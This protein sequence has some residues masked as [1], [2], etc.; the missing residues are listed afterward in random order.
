MSIDTRAWGTYRLG[1]LFDIT[2]G[3]YVP[4][5]KRTQGD[6]P[7]VT[8]TTLNNG[9]DGTC[10][11]KPNGA[12]GT[13]T[14][15]RNGS[16]GE[17][18]YQAD[19]Y[20]AT[21]DVHILT[22]K[23]ALS[24][25]SALFIC[26]VLRLEK[27]RYSYGRKWSLDAMKDTTIRLPRRENGTPDWKAMEAWVVAQPSYALMNAAA[28][29]PASKTP[30]TLPPINTWKPFRLDELFEVKRGGANG[31]G[32]APLV[33]AS[34]RN[35]GITGISTGVVYPA[36][37]ITVS[38]NGSI[39]EAFYQPAPFTA[40]GDVRVLEPKV[41]LTNESALFVC[42]VIRAERFRYSYG[43][44]WGLEQMRSTMLRLPTDANGDPDWNLMT[45]Y[46]RTLPYSGVL[47]S[48]QV[49]G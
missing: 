23:T 28:E 35:N 41:K 46:I 27:F 1:D 37:M 16:I 10:G 9:R 22:P 39:G 36:G 33:S 40:S 4:V 18:F 25:E 49:T 45:E 30:A 8:S 34:A 32:E 2:R 21:D 14:V 42:T 48:S 15:A 31:S 7:R 38:W 12:A 20:F 3:Q 29:T 26:T 44:K 17:S 11:M 6:T 47:I 5:S 24:P 19:A 43:R 13:I